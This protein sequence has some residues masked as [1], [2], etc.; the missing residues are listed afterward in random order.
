MMVKK[1]RGSCILSLYKLLA[2]F[3]REGEENKP[4]QLQ[5]DSSLLLASALKEPGFPPE[6]N[7]TMESLHQQGF[8]QGKGIAQC[9]ILIRGQKITSEPSLLNLLYFKRTNLLSIVVCQPVWHRL[10]ELP[11]IMI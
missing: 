4:F 7:C 10:F 6:K 9:R 8:N 3:Y 1:A 5:V 11:R 2:P